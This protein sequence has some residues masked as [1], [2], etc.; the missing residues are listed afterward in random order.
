MGCGE[1][2]REARVDRFLLR[3]EKASKSCTPGRRQLA[4]ND[5]GNLRNLRP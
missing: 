5:S 1:E 3:V 4:K 2:D